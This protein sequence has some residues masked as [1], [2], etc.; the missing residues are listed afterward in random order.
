M[1]ESFLLRV[2]NGSGI[3]KKTYCDTVLKGR[4]HKI[5]LR[6]T[7]AIMMDSIFGGRSI[8]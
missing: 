8:T 7:S 1:L 2:K 4:A 3:K 5:Q 6:N